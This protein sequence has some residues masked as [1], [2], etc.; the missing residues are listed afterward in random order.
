[1]FMSLRFLSYLLLAPESAK[2]EKCLR[3]IAEGI[4]WV[5]R[6]R[7]RNL[8]WQ[9]VVSLMEKDPSEYD[10]ILKKEVST[11]LSQRLAKILGQKHWLRF[12]PT[13]G[14]KVSSLLA[15]I[16][17]ITVK[18]QS[19]EAL[20]FL[21]LVGSERL[22]GVLGLAVSFQPFWRHPEKEVSVFDYKW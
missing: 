3:I 2:S 7:W 15:T 12:P 16:V 14:I 19:F 22:A 11:L 18:K 1:M 10:D 8:D 9:A 6:S 4:G 20:L 5:L 13:M 17:G 21:I